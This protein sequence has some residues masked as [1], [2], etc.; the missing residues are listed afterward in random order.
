M[1]IELTTKDHTEFVTDKVTFKEDGD[2]VEVKKDGCTFSVK[3]SEL[4]KVLMIIC[5]D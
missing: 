4:R 1:K 2:Y 5:E 3:K